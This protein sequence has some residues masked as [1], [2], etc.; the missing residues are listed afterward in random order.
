MYEMCFIGLIAIEIFGVAIW[1]TFL[2]NELRGRLIA[3]DNE[4]WRVKRLIRSL[5]FKL[6][7]DAESQEKT[8][9]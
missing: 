3:L 9:E 1:I 2:N 5:P 7:E 4:L 6:E 8:E